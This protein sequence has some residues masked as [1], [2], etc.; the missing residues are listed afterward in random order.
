[1]RE[2][3][4]A[5]EHAFVLAEGDWITVDDLPPEI[6]AGTR[7]A[8]GGRVSPL[9]AAQAPV[10]RAALSHHHGNR[11]HAARSLGISRNTLWRKMRALGL[12]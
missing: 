4:N 12:E 7:A 6:T 9:E 11:T 3:K 2:L 8:A 5:I 1:V 10:I